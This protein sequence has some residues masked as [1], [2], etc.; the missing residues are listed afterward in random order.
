MLSL[1]QESG[2][3][4]K[5]LRQPET[6]VHSSSS[7]REFQQRWNRFEVSK[8][9]SAVLAELSIVVMEEQPI[10][11]FISYNHRDGEWA[12][13]IACELEHAG[14]TCI[15]QAWDFVPGANFL[16]E[17]HHALLRSHRVIAILSAS[18]FDVSICNSRMDICVRRSEKSNSVA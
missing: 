10:D 8:S 15:I 9:V 5:R 13:W 17:M 16:A 14:Y 3:M 6:W 11:F 2:Q 4:S 18:Y 1:Q 12:E 7:R